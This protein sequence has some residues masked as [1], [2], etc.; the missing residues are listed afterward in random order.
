MFATLAFGFCALL[1]AHEG[2]K[3]VAIG[4]VA[5]QECVAHL[6]VGMDGAFVWGGHDLEIKFIQ[7]GATVSLDG[8]E[9][10][11]QDGEPA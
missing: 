7:G 8:T 2:Q 3:V 6:I 5:N 4:Y 10:V 9:T 11:L 1:A